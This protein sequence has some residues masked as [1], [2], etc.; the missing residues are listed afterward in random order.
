[1]FVVVHGRRDPLQVALG[2]TLKLEYFIFG[3]NTIHQDLLQHGDR[4]LARDSQRQFLQNRKQIM[5]KLVDFALLADRRRLLF[6][7]GQFT[8]RVI[9][10][11]HDHTSVRKS[12]LLTM[13]S[14]AKR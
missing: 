4:F 8:I 5:S 11:V 2:G 7:L 10:Q 1:V 12:V 3:A 14:I 13:E 9:N 6:T